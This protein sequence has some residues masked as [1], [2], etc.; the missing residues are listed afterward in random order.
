MKTKRIV[1]LALAGALAFGG[2]LVTPPVLADGEMAVETQKE[3]TQ[4]QLERAAEDMSD[5]IADYVDDAQKKVDELT[6][7][8]TKD[9]LEKKATDT[10]AA[11]EAAEAELEMA[12][13][14]VDTAKEAVK[15]AERNLADAKTALDRLLQDNDLPDAKEETIDAKIDDLRKNKKENEAGALEAAKQGI[16]D[17]QAM[18]DQAQEALESANNDLKAANNKVEGAEFAVKK[19]TKPAEDAQAALEKANKEIEA[20]E[21]TLADAKEVQEKFDNMDLDA[22]DVNAHMDTKGQDPKA[23][24][25]AVFDKANPGMAAKLTAILG[26]MP[27]VPGTPDDSQKPGDSEQPGGEQK[28]GDSQNPAKPD[29]NNK[30]GKKDEKKDKKDKKAPKTG[31]ISVLAYAG[32]AVLA[33]GA[34]VASKK[35]K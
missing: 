35:R 23:V 33:A 18:V 31:D 13:Q 30:D 15:Q 5:V 1:A 12:K 21:K 28:P 24:V 14:G 17:A 4:K 25:K 32:S 34:F 19:A 3:V 7:K 26:N 2:V 22:D 16:L 29:M 8:K 10:K 11:K 20:A 9:E 27:I 6:E